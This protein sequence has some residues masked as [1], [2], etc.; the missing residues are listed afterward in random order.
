MHTN[1][2]ER[3]FPQCSQLSLPEKRNEKTHYEIYGDLVHLFLEKLPRIDRQE[4]D[5]FFDTCVAD[6]SIKIP[7]DEILNAY[8]EAIGVL[9]DEKISTL[10]RFSIA[11]EAELCYNGLLKRLDCVTSTNGD[12]FVVDFKTGHEDAKNES[13]IAQLNSYSSMLQRISPGKRVR[14][15]ILWTKTRKL[16]EVTDIMKEIDDESWKQMD[17]SWRA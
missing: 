15:F 13:Y 7:E 8:Q 6:S 16:F 10:M 3:Q 11:S 5:R 17:L 4:W 2:T 14:A 1:T 12:L 9:L